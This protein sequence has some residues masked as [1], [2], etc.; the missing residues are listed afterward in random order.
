MN[1]QAQGAAQ[2]VIR[3]R[4]PTAV[5]ATEGDAVEPKVNRPLAGLRV[6]LRQDTWRSYHAVCKLW[7]EWL[8]RDGAVPVPLFVGDRTGEGGEKTRADLQGW[9]GSIDCAVSGL[10]T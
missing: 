6:G 4:K 5:F 2:R 7:E 3:V 9:A 10:G 8:R 1:D